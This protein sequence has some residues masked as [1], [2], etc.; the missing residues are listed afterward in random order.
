MQ[1]IIQG[2]GNVFHYLEP[3]DNCM[4]IHMHKISYGLYQ[5]KSKINKLN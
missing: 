2:A 4:G 3:S 5:W 1:Q